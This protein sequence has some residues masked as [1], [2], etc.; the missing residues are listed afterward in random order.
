MPRR[1]GR[2]TVRGLT[3]RGQSARDQ[4]VQALLELRQVVEAGRAEDLALAWFRVDEAKAAVVWYEAGRAPAYP[5]V[6]PEEQALAERAFRMVTGRPVT[7]A[8]L[9]QRGGDQL[10]ML[11]YRLIVSR[12]PMWCATGGRR[13][14]EA[15]RLA[16]E[17]MN[18]S[19]DVLS[20]YGRWLLA[21]AVCQAA[22]DDEEL[23]RQRERFRLVTG[24][25]RAGD[26]SS[27][28]FISGGDFDLPLPTSLTEVL[29]QR[30]M[31]T[32]L[33]AM[34]KD[35][36]AEITRFFLRLTPRG[37]Q[38]F[39]KAFLR[40]EEAYR[41]GYPWRKPPWLASE[42]YV[43]VKTRVHLPAFFIDRRP[44]SHAMFQDFVHRSK[45]WLPSRVSSH[46]VDRDTY[47]PS[48]NGDMPSLGQL[49]EPVT[50]VSYQAVRAYVAAHGKQLPTE[51][52]WV[53]ALVGA[54]VPETRQVG[55]E[56]RPS[57]SDEER[58]IHGRRAAEHGLHVLLPERVYD[59]D[60]AW[61]F[62]VDDTPLHDPRGPSSGSAHVWR[63]PTARGRVPDLAGD[64][65]LTFRG[66]VPA[67]RVWAQSLPAADAEG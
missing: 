48:W 10:S 37:Q 53:F 15:L 60:G 7:A 49:N 65:N 42:G 24:D 12:L 64:A 47:L 59:F 43:F 33:E 27:M 63:T 18:H 17:L 6:L 2:V 16:Y 26:G 39:M 30:G 20:P 1:P 31:P 66:V 52:Q 29:D 61:H 28:M 5:A 54:E 3:R 57:M 45:V 21:A 41:N 51:A 44:I 23:A 36:P 22:R 55:A 13:A 11:R 19:R 58:A 46:A 56:S 14:A 4:L 67:S 25:Y 38:V 9:L 8:N 40:R 50:G 35:A 62:N 32:R 34:K